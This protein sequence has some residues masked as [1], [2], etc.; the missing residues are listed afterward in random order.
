MWSSAI[1]SR[2]VRL[3]SMTLAMPPALSMA[4]I[5]WSS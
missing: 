4:A 5:A 3:W 1:S 2:A